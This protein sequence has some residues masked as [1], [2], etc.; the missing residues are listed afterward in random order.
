MPTSGERTTTVEREMTCR[1]AV[2]YFGIDT[3][4]FWSGL[5][6]VHITSDDWATWECRNGHTTELKWEG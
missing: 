1:K 6:E 3:R 2:I 4:C 5:V